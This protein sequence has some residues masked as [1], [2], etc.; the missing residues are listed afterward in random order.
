MNLKTFDA[1][2]SALPN[3]TMVIQWR[4]AHVWK[5]GGKVFAV[6]WSRD[7]SGDAT[8]PFTIKVDDMASEFLRQETGV[9]IAPYFRSPSWLRFLPE[10]T[11]NDDDLAGYIARSRELIISGLPKKR[12]TSLL[13]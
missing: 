8:C 3:V 9:E 7:Q 10:C 11:I 4:G 5:I 12:Q 1:A 6:G 2:C 13:S